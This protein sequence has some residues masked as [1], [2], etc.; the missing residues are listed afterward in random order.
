LG[1]EMSW[2]HILSFSRV[3]A[4]PIVAALA[5][6]A[7]GDAFLIAAVVFALASVTDLLDGKL[8]RYSRQSSALGVFLDTTS[9]KVMVSLTLIGM[10][11]GHLAPAWVVMVIVGRE[12]LITGL[13]SYAASCNK[14][15]SAHIWG[16]GKAAF[17]MVAIG[18]VFVAAGGRAGAW[19][20]PL[21]PHSVWDGLYTGT[22]WL[23]AISAVLTIVSGSRYVIDAWPLLRPQRAPA[24][25][26]EE[27]RSRAAASGDGTR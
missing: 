9:D 16:K 25:I 24:N 6:S 20:A 19:L 12:F 1:A 26:T 11:M 14:V 5:V 8:A 22:S 21:F 27:R 17:T 23:L 10:A 15:I 18:S 4:G 7:P 2:P 3:V 13:R